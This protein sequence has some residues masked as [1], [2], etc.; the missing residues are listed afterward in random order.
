MTAGAPLGFA[1]A[2]VI[3]AG[4]QCLRARPFAVHLP[5]VATERVVGDLNVET[6]HTYGFDNDSDKVVMMIMIIIMIMIMT[7]AIMLCY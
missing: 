6:K 5:G 3:V 2:A 1:V 7:T 4:V